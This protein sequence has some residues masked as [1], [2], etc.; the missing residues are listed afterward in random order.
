M[1]ITERKKIRFVILASAGG[2]LIEW[3]DLFMALILANTISTQLFPPGDSKFLETL[4]IVVSSYFIRPIGSLLFGSIGDRVGRKYSFLVTLILMGVATVLIGCIPTFDQIGWFAP[5]LLLILRLMQGLAISG[6]YSGAVIYVAEHAPPGKRGYYTGFIQAS[7]PLALILSLGVVYLTRN[8][9]SDEQFN[10]FGWRLPFF[11]S[12]VLIALSYFLRRKLHE[13]PVYLELKQAGKT[14]K[15]P[16]RECFRSKENIKLML[17][18]I[19]G[20]N[21][22]Q[23]AAMHTSQ[24]VTLFFLQRTVKIPD[25]TALLI[26][27]VAFFFGVFLYQWFAALSDK[28]G[29]KKIILGGLLS[30]LVIIPLAF[31]LFLS[32]G[33]PNGLT[34]VHPISNGTIVIFI[35]LEIG[36][37]ISTAMLYG[38]MGAF[39]LELFPTKIRYTAMGFAHNIG[40]GAIGGATPFV[41]ELLK[42]IFIFGAAFA[43]FTGLIYPLLLV[44]IAI[45]VNSIAVPETFKRSLKDS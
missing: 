38:P 18:A 39:M 16:I 19:F 21:A 1:S 6:E 40:N 23:S 7:V 34:E 14:S 36:M 3:Y 12:A 41:T 35:L 30:S 33:N 31:H 22:A 27:T 11:L 43:P 4:A 26:L 25:T 37:M 10:S 24:F 45:I 8:A 5:A 15:T 17:A 20:G 44:I 13:S 32:L 29:R 28:V 2:T 42:S 9:L